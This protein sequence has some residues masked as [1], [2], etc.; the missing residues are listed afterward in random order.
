MPNGKN[1]ATAVPQKTLKIDMKDFIGGST[2]PKAGAQSP[3]KKR[4]QATPQSDRNKKASAADS[5]A[6]AQPTKTSFEQVK[7]RY[8]KLAR[9]NVQ[10]T[11]TDNKSPPKNQ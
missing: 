10:K 2:A 9:R 3:A 4:Q 7:D 8:N 1:D 11:R 5:S 6:K